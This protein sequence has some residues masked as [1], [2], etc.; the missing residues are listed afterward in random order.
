[1]NPYYY[2]FYIIYKC[3]KLTT[4]ENLQHLVP[5]SS[6]NVLLFGITNY[7]GVTLTLTKVIQFFPI[8][9][10]LFL[11]LFSTFP[12]I[13]YFINKSLFLYNSN[14]KKIEEYYDKTNRLKKIHF[15]LITIAYMAFSIILMILAGIKYAAS[16]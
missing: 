16:N 3:V 1:M 12:I 2:L 5:E 10:I 14:Y 15:I 4:K 7:F 11:L 13:L 8:N 9:K 6:T